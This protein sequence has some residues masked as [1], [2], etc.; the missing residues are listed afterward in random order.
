MSD[1]Q[2]KVC[3]RC[4]AHKPLSLFGVN[5]A[6][7][8]G[9]KVW[10]KPCAD[11]YLREW[12]AQNPDKVRQKQARTYQ[13]H[14]EKRDA[15]SRRYAR[16]NPGRSAAYSAEW[17]KR[18]P[19][20]RRQVA[21]DWAKRNREYVA[22]QRASRRARLMRATPAWADSEFERLVLSEVYDLAKLRS[23]ATGVKHSVDHLVPLKSDRVC[24]LHCAANF[25]VIPLSLNKS[26]NN[27][28]W[29][30]MP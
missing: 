13:N 27:R 19:E 3:K 1:T 28:H 5:R 4:N 9:L 6:T 11:D 7:R 20:K 18:N 21:L 23:E 29:P 8:D 15:D 30:D 10:C 12:S 14:K 17:R 22:M 25:A 26:K 24:G 16:Q 2:G